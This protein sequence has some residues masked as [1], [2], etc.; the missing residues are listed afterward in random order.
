MGAVT[1]RID[2]SIDIPR[3][4]PYTPEDNIVLDGRDLLTQ[5]RVN[6]HD[7]ICRLDTKADRTVFYKPYYD[8]YKAS[9]E[10]AGGVRHYKA[11]TL[12]QLELKVAGQGVSVPKVNVYT[13]RVVSKDHLMCNLG[14]DVLKHF[15]S[16]SINLQSMSLD[17]D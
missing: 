14:Q 13:E 2:R 3:E 11:Y 9:V 15:K 16:Y 10:K 12:P 17:L 8:R 6:G 4:V 7:L 5:A 1:T